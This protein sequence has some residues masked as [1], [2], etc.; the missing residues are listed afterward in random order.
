MKIP[1]YQVNAF[2]TSFNGGN[3][4]GVCLLEDWLPDELMQAIAK[5][6]NLSETAFVVSN[7]DEFDLRWFTPTVEVDLCGHTTLASA[8]ALFCELN[9]Q[10]KEIKFNTRS[11]RLVVNKNENGYAMLLPSEK[12][13]EAQAPLNLVKGLK[14]QP[15]EVYRG[16]DYLLVFDSEDIIVNM[17]PDFSLVQNIDLRGTIVT[18]PS[19]DESVD[20]VS[21]FFGSIKVGIE[22]DPATGSAHC[23]LARYWSARLAKSKLVA[24]Q[25]SSRGAFLKCEMINNNTAVSGQAVTYLQGSLRV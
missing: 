5:E 7:G 3:P 13:T 21:R 14:R 10:K 11:G 24:K 6:N 23:A 17:K 18:A 9:Y 2:T 22:E 8:H 15:V 20:F 19:D 1:Y 4:A 25:L 12:L 16:T